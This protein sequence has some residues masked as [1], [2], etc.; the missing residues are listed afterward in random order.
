MSDASWLNDLHRLRR[1]PR[2]GQERGTW[3]HHRC[4]PA[5]T[6]VLTTLR[7]PEGPRSCFVRLRPRPS[8]GCPGL[9]RPQGRRGEPTVRD[10]RIAFGGCFKS[11]ARHQPRTS[12]AARPRVW[13]TSARLLTSSSTK[14]IPPRQRLQDHHGA[15]HGRVTARRSHPTPGQ[16]IDGDLAGQEQKP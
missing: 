2:S 10:V 8:C 13:R 12:C 7:L 3:L 15:Q 9:G 1:Q 14:W 16:A 4:R 11:L 6:L 5:P